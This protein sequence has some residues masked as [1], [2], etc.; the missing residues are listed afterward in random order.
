M[1]G[2]ADLIDP[3]VCLASE[4]GREVAGLILGLGVVYHGSMTPW[5]WIAVAALAFLAAL[6]ATRS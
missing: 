3:N 2:R 5:K 4:S 6:V 1:Q